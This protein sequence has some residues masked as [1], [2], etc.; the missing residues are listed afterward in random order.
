MALA[1]GLALALVL[2]AQE[3]VDLSVVQR[4]KTEALENSWVM[5][6]VFYLA[7]VHGPR[8]TGSPVVAA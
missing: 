1:L 5:N 4:I 6:H 3:S 2:V 8:L 7:D